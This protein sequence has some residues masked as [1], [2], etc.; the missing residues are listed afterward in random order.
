MLKTIRIGV[1]RGS[2]DPYVDAVL[3]AT[4][5]DQRIA[6]LVKASETMGDA[7]FEAWL[8]R[9]VREG[10]ISGEVA[11]TTRKRLREATR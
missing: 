10:V 5:N 7:A 3:G 8:R 2:A 1:A 4:S 9:A 6:V 11:S